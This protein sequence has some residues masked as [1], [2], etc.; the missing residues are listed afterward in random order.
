ME[1]STV[2]Q[3]VQN[4]RSRIAAAGKNAGNKGAAIQQAVTDMLQGMGIPVTPTQV[5]QRAAGVIQKT[6][7]YAHYTPVARKKSGKG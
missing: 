6:K 5:A 3:A 1:K 2:D 4:L 7:S